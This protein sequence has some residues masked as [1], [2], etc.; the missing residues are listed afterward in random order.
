MEAIRN[1]HME[2]IGYREEHRDGRVTVRN[3]EGELVGWVAWRLALTPLKLRTSEPH[4]AAYET[5]TRITGQF[6]VFGTVLSRIL[7]P[8]TGTLG[9]RGTPG[10]R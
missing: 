1:E 3:K 10:H 7:Q 8:P 6:I 2:T 9:I 4:L 5:Y